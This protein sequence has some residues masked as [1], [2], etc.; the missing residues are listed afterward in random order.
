MAILSAKETF[1]KITSF[2]DNHSGNYTE[3]YAGIAS[4]PEERLFEEHKVSK[5]SDF[6]IYQRCPNK[7]SAKGVEEALLKLGCDGGIGGGDES[8]VFAYAYRK[9]ANTDP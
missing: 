3:W 6:S 9:S 1:D 8:S 2:I 4:D 5:D 7:Q